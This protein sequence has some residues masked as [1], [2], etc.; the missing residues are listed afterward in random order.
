[1]KKMLLILTGIFFF[2]SCTFIDDY[3][4]DLM[5]D[6]V[7]SVETS[8][9]IASTNSTGSSSDTEKTTSSSRDEE[10]TSSS[11]FASSSSFSCSS[12]DPEPAEGSSSSVKNVSSSSEEEKTSSSIAESS[13]SS[14]EPKSSSSSVPGFICGDSTLSRGGVEYETVK[15]HNLCWTKKNLEFK[16]S[17][18]DGYMCYGD[19]DDNCATYGY[20]YNYETA[21]S[22]CQSSGWRLPTQEDLQNLLE[23]LDS[24]PEESA[25]YLKATSGWEGDPGNG[26]DELSF[27]AL[28]GGLCNA[29][30]TCSKVGSLGYWWTSTEKSRTSKYVLKLSGDEDAFYANSNLDTTF[31]ASVR[32][33][34][35]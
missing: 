31:F 1:M 21:W 10:T 28:P 25:A 6:A 3:D 35:E 29:E 5:Q 13:S 24:Y 12:K 20:L 2:A 16:P 33:V 26:N 15:I 23:Y 8:S 19:D 17:A 22:V 18:S 14:N 27:T 34:R 30:G 9:S 7:A 11:E 32:C 4:I